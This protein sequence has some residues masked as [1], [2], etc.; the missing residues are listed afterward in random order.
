[1]NTQYKDWFKT[2]EK[3]IEDQQAIS[4]VAAYGFLSRGARKY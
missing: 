2:P 4:K 3:T 1:M